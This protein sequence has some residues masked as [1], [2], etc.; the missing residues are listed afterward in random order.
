MRLKCDHCCFYESL[1]DNKMSLDCAI[2]GHSRDC[3]A[4]FLFGAYHMTPCPM[5]SAFAAEKLPSSRMFN[6]K[7]C[8]PSFPAYRLALV[9]YTM[10]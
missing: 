6:P 5:A 3:M 4:P 8:A 10:I 1:H 7:S 2:V 9:E